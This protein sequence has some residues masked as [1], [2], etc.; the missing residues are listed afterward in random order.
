MWVNPT[1]GTYIKNNVAGFGVPAT[2]TVEAAIEQVDTSTVWGILPGASYGTS[3]DQFLICNTHTDGTNIFEENGG[4]AVVN[5]A[6]YFAQVPQSA[7]AKSMVFMASTGH[8]S[9]G[10]LGSSIDWIEQ[11]P[12]IVA[13]TTGVVTIEHLGATE[14]EDVSVNGTLRYR[15][16]GKLQQSEVNITAPG[17]LLDEPGPPDPTLL[18]ITTS[19]LPGSDDRG[20]IVSGG[21]FFGEGGAFHEIGIPTIG[22]IP[23]PIYLCAIYPDGGIAR[24]NPQHFHSQVADMVQ[25]LLAM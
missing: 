3:G 19:V 12:Q 22:Y 6:S 5:V 24:L 9:H 7:R 18:N 16:S 21:L 13:S 25:C 20:A 15:P 11:H 17:F 23:L 10:F 8:F 4:I 1:Q 2:I 14:W